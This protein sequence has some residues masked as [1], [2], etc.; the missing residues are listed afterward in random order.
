VTDRT[1]GR[2]A[3]TIA[4]GS[5]ALLF[6]TA[7]FSLHYSAESDRL[8]L[9]TVMLATVAFGVVGAIIASRT[10]N[11]V[12]W[13][14]LAVIAT[15]AVSLSTQ[16]YA[17]YSI[18]EAAKR[19]PLTTFIAWV[20]TM[21]FFLALAL[22]VAI[23]LLFPTGTPRWRWVWRLYVASTVALICGFAVLPQEMSLLTGDVQG[24]DNPFAIDAIAGPVGV[25]TGIAG[26][27]IL[28]CAAL[29]II[30]LVA[31]YRGSRG[32]E[33]QQ[34]RW[35]AYVGV[36][37]AIAFLANVV[38]GA[39]YGSDPAPGLP[40]A[41][42]EAAFI[43]FLW[44]VVFGIPAACGVAILKYRL[45]DLDIV[46]RKAV[47]FTTVAITLTV[48]YL[49]VLALATVGNAPRIVV[50]LLL[51]VVTF[52]PV[53]RGARSLADRVAY[54]KRAS[55]YEILTDFSGRVGETY[56]TE[57]VLP[58]MARILAEGTGAS[59]AR[60]FLRLG[61]ELRPVAVWPPEATTGDDEH[62]VPVMHQGEELGALGV[63]MP[64]ND[65]WD[66]SRERLAGDL[67]AQAGL[68]LRNVKLIEELR[69]SRQRLVAAQ[70][71]ER[72]KIERNLHD[73]VQ[74][75]LVAMNVQLGLLARVAEGD[76]AKAIDMATML[77]TRATEAL[78]DLRDLARGIYPPLLADKGLTAALEAQARKAAVPTTVTSRQ[79]ARY[80]QD[81][82]SAVYF[83]ALEALNN[84][85]KYANAS[86][87]AVTLAQTNGHLTFSVTD[88]GVG[89]D[90]EVQSY[91]TGMQGMADRLDA[92]GGALTVTSQPGAGTTV[93]GSIPIREA[94]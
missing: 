81:V 35:L 29:S 8:L 41:L 67:A 83:C 45:Y 84:I 71:E 77:Q 6:P 2:L 50:G 34:I 60:V 15:L 80:P 16:A 27:A 4:I 37:A 66:A 42:S 12:G 58:R 61:P 63:T 14:L 53:L 1:R 19:L 9:V 32:D 87:V 65:T 22:I 55:A 24:P 62:V 52:R 76:P 17:T 70:D 7:L 10:G 92:I 38:V 25:I 3:W 89:F 18:V 20:D 43:A 11:A 49:A 46:V 40:L 48:L 56:A 69:A 64:A 33:R 26:L 74:Q 31:Q 85:A 93:T 30:S 28:V 79:I 72:R 21:T 23:P 59:A 36:A 90:A 88:D 86:G 13:A 68:V 73:G 51:L 44:I 78:D 91:G 47:V 54:G 39:S 82:E 94:S 75:Q 57:D 5:I